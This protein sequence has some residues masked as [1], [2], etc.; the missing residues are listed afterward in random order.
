MSENSL[1]SLAW[2]QYIVKLKIDNP[3]L[4]VLT[5]S[6]LDELDTAFDKVA[7]SEEVRALIIYG[8]G[9]KAFV[10]GADIKQFPSLTEATG[11]ELVKKGK[12]IFDKI[13]QA[14]FPVICAVNGLALGG[15]LELAMACDMR[16][17]DEKAK[18]GLPET[19]LGII[20]GYGGT[21][22]L[23]RLIGPGKTKEMIYTGEPI[24][25]EEAL[26]LGLIEHI[27]SRG[28]ALDEALVIANK[29]AAKSPLALSKAKHAINR[30]GEKSLQEGQKLETEL[31]G[32]L[33]VSEDK[34]EG[35]EAFLNKRKPE[36]TGK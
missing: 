14:R 16:I 11:K 22:R 25:A 31:F 2:E 19:G 18:L 36:F 23:T 28:K 8:E 7:S 20:P 27:A 33:C 9:E 15:G 35:V 34:R 17:A 26:R 1:I 12:D 29:I 24:S 3:P 10:A 21:Q 4:N 13:A 32:E 30:G 5:N 6:L